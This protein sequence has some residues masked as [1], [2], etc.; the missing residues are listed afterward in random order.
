M[1][2]DQQISCI[3]NM[4]KQLELLEVELNELR[5]ESKQ[6]IDITYPI[7][8]QAKNNKQVVKFTGLNSITVLVQGIDEHSQKVGFK[9]DSYIPHTNTDYW[10]PIAFDETRGIADKQL[11][12]CWARW[13]TH[14]RVLRFY[15]AL[16]R[17]AFN[18]EGKRDGN[19]WDNYRP[20]PYA[21]YPDWAIEA[22][23]TLRD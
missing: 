19:V 22:E 14:S 12:E 7:Y 16:N 3:N 13:Y 6:K 18:N 10:Q 15:D 20:I 21:D 4:R 5:E 2:F 9:S 17:C 23:K 8:M 11:C 1:N